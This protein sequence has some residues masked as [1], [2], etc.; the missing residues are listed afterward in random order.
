MQRHTDLPLFPLGQPLFPGIALPLRIF[1]QRYLKLVRDALR[2]QSGFA[3]L[4]IVS[5]REVGA[6]PEVHPWGTLVTIRDWSQ[7]QD[8]LLG[9]TVAGD[10][11]VRVENIRAQADGLLVAD[12]E[13]YPPDP[14][15]L[16]GEA[17]SDLVTLLASLAGRLGL[18]ELAPGDTLT[19]AD[20]GWRLLTL[21]PFDNRWRFAQL[22]LDD[23]AQRLAA[24]REHLQVLGRR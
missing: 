8:G 3:V 16:V 7:R 22:E 20:L 10:R 4:P 11:R 9:I 24:I 21:M 17:E 14:P 6:P 18:S 1:E 2:D 12:G 19:V 13:I 5:G 15:R 23:P